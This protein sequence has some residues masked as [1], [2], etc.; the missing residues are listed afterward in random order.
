MRKLTQREIALI[1]AVGILAVIGIVYSRGG[2]LGRAAE[3][4]IDPD[5]LNY[6]APPVVELARLGLEPEGFGSG[7]RNLFQ[8]YTPPPPPRPKPPPVKPPP[9]TPRPTT[10]VRTQPRP[11]TA[12]PP[13]Q[14]APRPSFRYIGFMGPKDN[15]IAVLAKGEEVILASLGETV[16]KQFTIREFR[17]EMLVIGY[18][19]ERWADETHELPMKR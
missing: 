18:T 8:Y 4:E 10:P 3:Q 16:D 13:V 2:P 14:Q 19:Q 1:T 9:P 12:A 17:Y 11:V 6:G 15:K 7:S 5:K